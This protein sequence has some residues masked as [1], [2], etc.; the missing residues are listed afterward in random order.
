MS[1]RRRR[2]GVTLL[3]MLIVLAIIGVMSSIVWP[4]AAGALDS[5]R[6]RSSADAVASLLAK[7]T[8][9]ADR[10]QQPVEI[11]IDRE[12]GRIEAAGGSAASRIEL[13]LEEGIA[14]ASVEPRGFDAAGLEGDQPRQHRFVLLP[15]AGWPALKIAL[16][17]KGRAR[18]VVSLDPITGAPSVGAAGEGGAR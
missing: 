17:S 6:L 11:V 12:A 15:G 3:E 9:Q 2:R 4:T 13:T 7:A 8:V 10:R 5:I 18:R 14:I 1:R 16:E